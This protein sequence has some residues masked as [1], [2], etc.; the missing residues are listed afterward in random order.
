MDISDIMAA[1]TGVKR[2]DHPDFWTLSETVLKLKAQAKE[3]PA[4]QDLWKS[5]Y[6]AIGD[7][8]SIAYCAIQCGLDIM[9][10]RNGADWTALTRDRRKHGKYIAIVQAFFDGFVMGA[11]LQRKR[12]A[13][14]E[15]GDVIFTVVSPHDPSLRGSLYYLDYPDGQRVE[16]GDAEDHYHELANIIDEEAEK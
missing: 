11:A 4:D 14:V 7:F 9:G 12:D 8:D 3:R 6:E 13:E 16:L 2:P 5:N 1:P 10:I 15:G